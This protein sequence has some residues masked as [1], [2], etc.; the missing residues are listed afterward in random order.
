MK[1]YL[2]LC[3]GVG[4]AKLALGFSKILPNS[5]LTIAVNTGDDFNHLGLKICPDLDTVL[6]TLANQSDLSKGWGRSNESWE[7]LAAL[8]K[9]GGETWFQLGD[10]DLATH[11]IR[12]QLLVNGK[13]LSEITQ[14][15]CDRFGVKANI[16]PMSHEPVETYIQTQNRLLSFQEYFVKFKCD[17]PVTDFVFKGLD[18]AVFNPSINLT[19]FDEIIVCPSNPFVSINPIIQLD[20]IN[21]YLKSNTHKVSVVSP[22]VNSKSLKGP[23]SKIMTELGLDVSVNAIADFYMDYAKTIFVDSLDSHQLHQIHD[24]GFETHTTPLV[25]NNLESKIQLAQ[26]IFNYLETK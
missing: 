5:N 25:M 4:G 24:K 20:G 6:Y 9:L 2:L 15:L 23:T 16:L 3:G 8:K 1:N 14:E 26:S 21:Q 11:I 13:N 12:T 7:M 17:P 18:K 19:L 22:I 10:K